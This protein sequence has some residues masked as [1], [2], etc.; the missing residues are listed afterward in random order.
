[1]KYKINQK[2]IEWL[3]KKAFYHLVFWLSLFI[4]SLVASI[5]QMGFGLAF[6]TDIVNVSFFAFIVYLNL[7]YLFPW[8]RKHKNFW[9]HFFSLAGAA[10]LLTPI[11]T[12]LFFWATTGYPEA[13]YSYYSNQLFSFIS[14]FFAGASATIY[15]I[16]NEWLVQQR[17]KK[18]LESQNL[19]SELKFLKS[20]INPHFLFNT[21]NSLYALTLKKSDLA[22]EIVLK[23]S[24]MMRYMLY[25]CNE[26]EVPLSKEINYM[27]NYLEL[28]KLRHGNKM[29]ID[30]K[31]SGDLEDKK[32]APLIL[33][34]FIENSFKHGVSNQVTHG[35]VNLELIV[36]ENDLHMEL[37]NSKA[38]SLP[39]INGKRSGGIG[40]ANVKRRMMI[41]YPEKH[42][43]NISESPNTYK[44]ELDL[45][46]SN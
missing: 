37:E 42:A 14:T 13:Q 40:L 25:E 26:K 27:Q 39:K 46:L 33:I 24:E 43:L 29:L 45:A 34:P 23:L 1:M 28:E 38:P 21:L 31:V 11:K 6:L 12:V 30:L 17:D 5:P 44:I 19:Q 35:F 41:L 32:I 16:T 7:F 22:P 15:Q 2:L 10:L 36:Q 8:Y 9:Y 20:Q 3:K 4:V 18:E